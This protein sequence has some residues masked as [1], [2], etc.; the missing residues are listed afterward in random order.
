MS[1]MGKDQHHIIVAGVQST[2]LKIDVEKGRILD[3]VKL[4]ILG[5]GLC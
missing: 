4:V 1:F 3:R 2:I 5:C